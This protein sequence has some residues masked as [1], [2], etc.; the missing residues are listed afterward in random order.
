MP[1]LPREG[2]PEIRSPHREPGRPACPGRNVALMLARRGSPLRTAP[3]TPVQTR[4]AS[5][6]LSTA[7]THGLRELEARVDENTPLRHNRTGTSPNP[8]FR[9]RSQRS[10]ERR[11]TR[12]CRV[13]P[14]SPSGQRVECAK[15]ALRLH[16]RRTGEPRFHPE[17]RRSP[18]GASL[19][20]LALHPGRRGSLEGNRGHSV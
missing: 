1:R 3:R 11:K 7:R 15:R 19:F 18:T 12:R 9:H 2:D 4:E 20:V 6:I 14:R 17:G 13:C 16:S 8:P 5:T 10:N